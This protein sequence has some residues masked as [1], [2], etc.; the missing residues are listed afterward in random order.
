MGDGGWWYRRRRQQG[1]RWCIRERKTN[2]EGGEEQC[3]KNENRNEKTL[4]I[5]KEIRILRD[6]PSKNMRQKSFST[7]RTCK[8]L[9]RRSFEL[10]NNELLQW[11]R[12]NI[13]CINIRDMRF[14][15]E[16][17]TGCLFYYNR[18]ALREWWSVYS[19]PDLSDVTINCRT[20]WAMLTPEL[21]FVSFRWAWNC[22]Y[23][24]K[25]MRR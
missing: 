7:K 15:L 22:L 9:K 2:D 23:R 3:W 25:Y 19:F 21:I 20:M 17:D 1:R 4:S 14:R 13:F 18:Q 24:L 12:F 5:T 10:E 16:I 6:Y 8:E 11:N